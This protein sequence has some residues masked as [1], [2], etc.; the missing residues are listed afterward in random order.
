MNLPKLESRE[1]LLILAGAAV[2]VVFII[3]FSVRG[4]GP[5][6]SGNADLVRLQKTRDA[7]MVDLRQYRTL[8]QTIDRIDQKLASTPQDYDLFGTVSGV[9]E[10]LGLRTAIR[11]IK[12][13]QSAGTDFF[14]E[15]YVDMDMQGITLNDLVKLLSEIEKTPAFIR[16]SNLSVTKR[17]GEEKQLN[18]NIRVTAYGLKS[19][20]AAP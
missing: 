19:P 7:F 15:A 5:K 20:E 12:P 10:T 8:K 13:N 16:V 18:V 9:V 1:K 14:T 6:R 17:I 2:A 3:V 4:C 11:N